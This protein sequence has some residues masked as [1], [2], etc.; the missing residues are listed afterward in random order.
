MNT[1]PHSFSKAFARKHTI[2]EAI[3][4]EEIVFKT[5]MTKNIREGKRWYYASL[6]TLQ[7]QL[8]YLTRDDISVAMEMMVG[9]GL[10]EISTDGKLPDSMKQWLCVPEKY[11]QEVNHDKVWFRPFDASNYGIPA[12]LLISNLESKLCK[13]IEA[14]TG[15]THPLDSKLLSEVLPLSRTAINATLMELVEQG[16]LVKVQ[17]KGKE[18]TLSTIRMREIEDGVLCA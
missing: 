12:A 8:P 16:V 5:L 11:W 18:Y 10:L 9:K 4:I 13:N 17:R 7:K 2:N 1:I 6:Q 15:R 14:G 3:V